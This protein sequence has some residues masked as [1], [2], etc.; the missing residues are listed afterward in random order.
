MYHVY[1]MTQE[2]YRDEL[3][4]IKGCKSWII[5]SVD[6]IISRE[7]VISVLERE[8]FQLSVY[9]GLLVAWWYGSRIGNPPARPVL[10]MANAIGMD[11][12]FIPC[13]D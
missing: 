9:R 13:R 6:Q 1:L 11:L 4:W 10:A 3:A 2:Q 5:A 12:V 8:V 7:G